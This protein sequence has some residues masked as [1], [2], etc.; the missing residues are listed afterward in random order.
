MVSTLTDGA[1]LPSWDVPPTELH[2]LATAMVDAMVDTVGIAVEHIVREGDT[3]PQDEL[4]NH[5]MD[6]Q[7]PGSHS[8]N[9]PYRHHLSAH[10]RDILDQFTLSI[11]PTNWISVHQDIISWKYASCVGR[12]VRPNACFR[13]TCC[14]GFFTSETR[15]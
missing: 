14:K 7:S 13:C 11:N 9:T 4:L 6:P 12:K 8:S 3:Q 1:Y 5:Q 2:A 10:L 15:S